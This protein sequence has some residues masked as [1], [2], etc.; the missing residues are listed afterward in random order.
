MLQ[1]ERAKK[2]SCRR[3][4]NLRWQELII[5]L[6]L[7]I[8]HSESLSLLFKLFTFWDKLYVWT[9][10]LLIFKLYQNSNTCST[11][12]YLFSKMNTISPCLV[13]KPRLIYHNLN[14]FSGYKLLY[15]AMQQQWWR[16]MMKQNTQLSNIRKCVFWSISDLRIYLNG[17]W[18]YDNLKS[19]WLW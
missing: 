10:V 7:S 8:R 4:I 12:K 9:Q 14:L 16:H 2:S 11:K 18:A 3:T 19:N 13:I 6:Y 1:H 5:R 17:F 15:S